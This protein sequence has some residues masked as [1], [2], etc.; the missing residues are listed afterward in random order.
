VFGLLFG[1]GGK[2]NFSLS[3]ISLGHGIVILKPCLEGE[4]VGM[5]VISTPEPCLSCEESWAPF[6]PSP[7]PELVSTS[8]HFIG[9]Y[10]FIRLLL[11]CSVDD[12]YN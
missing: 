3:A 9:L 12:D 10:A 8:K 4:W 11:F 1:T 7:F 2:D 5:K 6:I